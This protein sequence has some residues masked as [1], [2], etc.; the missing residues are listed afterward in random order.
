MTFHLFVGLQVVFFMNTNCIVQESSKT[1]KI[2]H[3]WKNRAVESSRIGWRRVLL[4]FVG[5]LTV[6]AQF[7]AGR[8][9]F[10]SKF[11]QQV[12]RR[13][14]SGSSRSQFCGSSCAGGKQCRNRTV[15]ERPFATQTD[16]GRRRTSIR[17]GAALRRRGAPASRPLHFPFVFSRLTR[18]PHIFPDP[19]IPIRQNTI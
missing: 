3:T 6:L 11:L 14:R 10:G 18:V 9:Q 17:A 19:F 7:S 5:R 1:D 8:R 13:G 12:K 2:S 16:D 15:G 4:H